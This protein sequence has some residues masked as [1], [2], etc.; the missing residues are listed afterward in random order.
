MVRSMARLPLQ[1]IQDDQQ[2]RREF[3]RKSWLQTSGITG[4]DA[5]WSMRRQELSEM[6]SQVGCP[7]FFTTFSVADFY[8]PDVAQLLNTDVNDRKAMVDAVIRNPILVDSYVSNKFITFVKLVLCRIWPVSDYWFRCEWQ[9]RGT[10]HFHGFLWMT[11]APPIDDINVPLDTFKDYID[12]HITCMNPL[13]GIARAQDQVHPATF[14]W[15]DIRDAEATVNDLIQACMVHSRCSVRSCLRKR[16][17]SDEMHCRY[18]FPK[19]VR[20]STEVT[21][22]ADG[23]IKFEL[24]ANDERVGSFSRPILLAWRANCNLQYC[25]NKSQVNNV[26]KVDKQTWTDIH[27]HRQ[28]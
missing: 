8:W 28:T 4:S 20:Q 16:R 17:G 5:Y 24:A 21:R 12:T 11:A 19:P 2:T 9:A 15:A 22:D 23:S 27:R 26:Y 25:Y 13:V 10:V 18:G 7:T 3:L 6:I 1:T 14:S